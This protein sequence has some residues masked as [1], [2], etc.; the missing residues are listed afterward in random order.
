MASWYA[1]IVFVFSI[2]RLVRFGLS[3]SIKASLCVWLQTLKGGLSETRIEK[4]IVITGDCDIDHD[5]VSFP[6][7]IPSSYVFQQLGW[8]LD[9]S[10]LCERLS[11]KHNLAVVYSR[12]TSPNFAGDMIR[13]RNVQLQLT[14][15]TSGDISIM[16]LA[17]WMHSLIFDLITYSRCPYAI[18]PTQMCYSCVS[19]ST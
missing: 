11:K 13:L 14:L 10:G 15:L 9:C 8:W 4:R 5:E 6:E 17:V 3:K 19:T 7:L 12:C 16:L 1:S 2:G 18:S